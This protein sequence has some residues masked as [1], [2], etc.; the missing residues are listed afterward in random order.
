MTPARRLLGPVLDLL[1]VLAMAILLSALSIP[2]LFALLG[3]VLVFLLLRIRS[4]RAAVALVCLSLTIGIAGFEIGLR[5]TQANPA[6][7]RP[8]EI[9]SRFAT[10]G[11]RSHYEPHRRL[12]FA[13]PHGDLFA[14][15]DRTAP[16][17]VEPRKVVFVTDALGYRNTVGPGAQAFVL[18]GDS[19]AAGSGT[20]QERILGETLRRAHGVDVY[21][22]AFPGD[23]VNYAQTL[24]WLK[25]NTGLVR[26]RNVVALVFEGND[27]PC[28]AP[29]APQRSIAAWRWRPV[30]RLETYRLFFGLTRAALGAGE[31]GQSVVVHPVGGTMV[32]FLRHYVDATTQTAPC[33]WTA[34]AA[35]LQAMAPNLALIA[36]A[37]T[38]YRVYADKLAAAA[39]LPHIR[40]AFIEA[41]AGRIGVPALDL[42]PLLQARAAALLPE[43]KYV[44]WRDDSHWNGEGM[45][46]A[47]QAI[48]AA[49]K[50]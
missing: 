25:A 1:L 50:R 24:D 48:A 12:D 14:L 30:T 49:L 28:A 2:G 44:Y 42:T 4:G 3:S 22:A 26:G 36:F 41:T 20:T 8:D 15:S 9:L 33:D 17:I 7:Y 11:G 10:S 32:G 13:M 34:Q 21:S 43:G 35:A 29:P 38:K 46:V 45:D 5:L 23:P 18:I 39:P 16:E 47:A 37:P 6:Y 27:L 40:W 31:R 19:F